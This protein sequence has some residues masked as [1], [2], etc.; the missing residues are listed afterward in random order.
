MAA[1]FGSAFLE[2]DS[3]GRSVFMAARPIDRGVDF[4]SGLNRP[5][6][7][8]RFDAK[9]A[10]DRAGRLLGPLMTYV[11]GALVYGDRVVRS[12]DNLSARWE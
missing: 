4:A 3:P 6:A 11:G 8:R 9:F 10:D 5:S 12:H 2:K 7:A 1:R